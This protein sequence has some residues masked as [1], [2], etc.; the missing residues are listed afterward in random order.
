MACASEFPSRLFKASRYEAQVGDDGV[1]PFDTEFL[2]W[3]L[4]DGAGAALLEDRPRAQG[5]SLRIDWIEVLSHADRF[6]VCM[7]AGAN[8]GR[9]GSRRPGLAGLPQLPGGGGRGGAQPEA[10]HPPA[11]PGGRAGRGPAVPADRGRAGWIPAALDWI[12][13]HYSSQFFRGRI[14]E[15]LAK[16][17]LHLPPERWFSNLT[18]KGNVGSASLFVLLEEL[19][20][21]AA[22]CAR[23]SSILV[24]IPESGRFSVAYAHLTVVG[25]APAAVPAPAPAPVP[26]AVAPLAAGGDHRATRSSSGWCASWAWCGSSSRRSCR[27]CPSCSGWSRGA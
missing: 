12:V 20:S 22:G 9:D 10:G 18:T 13:C 8:K 21:T 17:G 26:A 11:G 4:S 27:R 23:A 3:M 6:P 15:L 16:G 5:L 19:W 24:N 1:L 14:F 7:Y 2:R 25:E